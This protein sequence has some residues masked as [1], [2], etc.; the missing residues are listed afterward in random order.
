MGCIEATFEAWTNC[1]HD[2]AFGPV[3][4]PNE[5]KQCKCFIEE[6]PIASLKLIKETFFPRSYDT[7]FCSLKCVKLWEN[8]QE[9]DD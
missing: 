1:L 3:S 4:T 5:C 9:W 6:D 8:E 7:Y 2:Q